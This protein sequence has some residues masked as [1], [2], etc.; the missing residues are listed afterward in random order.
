MTGI[1]G[2]T[3]ASDTQG[4]EEEADI[5]IDMDEEGEDNEAAEEPRKASEAV[6][7][8]IVPI[9]KYSSLFIFSPTNP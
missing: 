7:T 9:P 6:P 8:K 2:C 4:F 3:Y 1:K 5:D